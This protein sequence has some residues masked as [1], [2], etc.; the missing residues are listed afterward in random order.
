LVAR[1]GDMVVYI[2]DMSE[3]AGQLI[4]AAKSVAEAEHPGAQIA[5]PLAALAF[6]AQPAR[7]VPFGVVAP[8]AD[9]LLVLLRGNITAEIESGADVHQLSGARALTW[10]DEIVPGPVH[11][12]VVSAASESGL[13]VAPH[14]DLREGVVLGGGFVLQRARAAQDQR[15]QPKSV[16]PEVTEYV[17]LTPPVPAAAAPAASAR[18]GRAPTETSTLVPVT[19]ALRSED[20]A[21]YPLDRPYVIGRNPVGDDAVRNESA[22]SIVVRDDPHVSRVHAYVTIDGDAVFVHDASTPAGTYIAPPGAKGWTEI[23]TTPTELAPGW[24][25]R[26]GQRILTYYG[27]TSA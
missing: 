24:S 20:G 17:E 22:S 6:G 19:G 18:T 8:T 15:S 16:P 26:I 14:T 9:G 11:R 13:S 23:G 25:L 21:V 3:S 1:F 7:T 4:A 12:V 10:V 27:A 2:A 5:E